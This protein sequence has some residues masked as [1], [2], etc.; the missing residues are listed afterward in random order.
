MIAADHLRILQ[1]PLRQRGCN[2]LERGGNRQL[3]RRA[4]PASGHADAPFEVFVYG[5]HRHAHIFCLRVELFMRARVV[6]LLPDEAAYLVDQG[7]ILDIFLVV[8][9]GIDKEALAVRER[10]RERVHQGAENR[11]AAEEVLLLQ[12]A[13][14]KTHSPRRNRPR[15]GRTVCIGGRSGCRSGFC[16]MHVLRVQGGHVHI[17]TPRAQLLN[18]GWW[19]WGGPGSNQWQPAVSPSVATV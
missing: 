15:F 13:H 16:G 3:L 5:V 6:R 17:L 1:R 11:V 10:R 4:E 18:S 9:H 2:V 7:W 19:L 8:P 12:Q 14:V